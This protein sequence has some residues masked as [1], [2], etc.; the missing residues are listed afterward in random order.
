MIEIRPIRSEADY[1][2]ALRA[3]KSL[4]GAPLATAEGDRLDV[5]VTLIDAYESEHFP[6]D[7]PDPD[8]LTAFEQEQKDV[9][10]AEAVVQMTFEIVKDEAGRFAFYLTKRS[11]EIIFR[12]E[13]FDRKDDAIAAIKVLQASA[14]NSEIIDMAA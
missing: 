11:G 7:A 10:A 4:W 6:M 3:V 8:A 12:S 13:G 2:K 14:S 1:E 5:L 9:H